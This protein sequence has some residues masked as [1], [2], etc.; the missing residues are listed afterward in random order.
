MDET[1][2]IVMPESHLINHGQRFEI[3]VLGC[4][5]ENERLQTLQKKR[6][7]F[8]LVIPQ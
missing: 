6:G 5:Q 3:L 1:L 2:S 8:L 7:V 4:F